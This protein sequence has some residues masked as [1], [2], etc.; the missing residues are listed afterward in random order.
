MRSIQGV[1]YNNCTNLIDCK[2]CGNYI[3]DDFNN[4]NCNGCTKNPF[5]IN[6]FTP[7]KKVKESDE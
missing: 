4:P 1:T 7:I 3:N 5:Y 2:K 6:C